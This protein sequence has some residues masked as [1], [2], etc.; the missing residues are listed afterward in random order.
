MIFKTYQPADTS[1]INCITKKYCYCNC[2]TKPASDFQYCFRIF[3]VL[4]V[5]TVNNPADAY[6]Q[7]FSKTKKWVS[8]EVYF[9]RI[10]NWPIFLIRRKGLNRVLTGV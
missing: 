6:R 2:N 7:V 9:D 3:A 8:H 5:S 1:L 10:Q 4:L